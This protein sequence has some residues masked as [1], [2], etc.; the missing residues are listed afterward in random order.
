MGNTVVV[1]PSE[2][3]PLSVL[4]SRAC[5]TGLP[6]DI[7]RVVP[8]VAARWVRAL[9][10]HRGVDKL[11]VHRLHRHGPGDHALPP[12]QG[13]RAS[14]PGAGWRHSTGV[15]LPTSTPGLCAEDLFWGAFIDAR[16]HAPPSSGCTCTR[17]CTTPCDALVEVAR[18]MPMGDGRAREQRAGPAAEQATVRHRGRTR[19]RM[20]SGGGRVLIGG[21]PA[22]GASR[23]LP[24]HPGGG[25][26]Q[27]QPAGRA[28]QFGPAL[29]S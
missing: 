16:R 25:P 29:P 3:T 22:G 13:S 7:L 19:G 17:T 14:P 26:A 27:R 5:S 8:P 6:A 9:S 21:G 11:H 15:V 10:E 28:E 1:K 2:Y 24:H 23:Y 4:V 20:P 12:R 18:Q